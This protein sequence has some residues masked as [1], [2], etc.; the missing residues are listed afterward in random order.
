MIWLMHPYRKDGLWLPTNIFPVV[1]VQLA[2]KEPRKYCSFFLRQAHAQPLGAEMGA[3]LFVTFSVAGTL[4]VGN[5][6]TR[7]TFQSIV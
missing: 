3:P 7:Y 6:N 5:W 4:E 2:T 1:K